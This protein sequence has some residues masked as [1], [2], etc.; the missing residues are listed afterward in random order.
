MD[1]FLLIFAATLLVAVLF[2]ALAGRTVL[3]A[4]VLFLLVGFVI[5]SETTG[6]LSFD[7][8]SSEVSTIAEIALFVVL[9]TDGMKMGWPDLRKAWRLPGRALG[10]GLPLTLGITAVLAHFLVGLDWPE[11]LLIGAI[12]APTDPVFA[13]ALVGNKRVP[14]RLRQLLNVESGVN[15]GLALPFVIVFLAVSSGSEDLHLGELGLELLIGTVIGIAVPWLVIKALHTRLFAA[16]GVFEPLVPIA[17]GLLVFALS[18]TLHANLFLAAFA[19]GVTVA[20][21]GQKEREEFEEFGEII[22]ELLKLLALMVFGALLSFKFL[23]EIA[24]TGWLFAILAL[25]VA[26][27]AA[28]FVSFLGSGL[29]M[30]EQVA[31]MWFGPKGFASVV[32]VLVVVS[33]DIPAGDLIFHLVALTIALSIIAHSS[34]DVVVARSFSEPGETP[35]WQGPPLNGN[36]PPN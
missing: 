27:P 20:T 13:A 5:G 28:L 11:A 21:V 36:G 23:G 17:I 25:I 1:T 15:D 16:A 6:I 4:A 7:S 32:Y 22:S 14:Q 30:R 10:W 18:T 33:A 19:A 29:S 8:A 31:A 26:R 34:T 12:L 9:F 35:A 2:S 3:S 24:W